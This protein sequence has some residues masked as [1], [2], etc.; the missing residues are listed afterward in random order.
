[1]ISKSDIEALVDLTGRHNKQAL[2]A[3]LVENV[4]KI[5]ASSTISVYEVFSAP[6]DRDPTDN[7]S[8]M[9]VRNTSNSVWLGEPLALHEGFTECIATKQVVRL[10][11]ENPVSTRIVF[12][13]SG[14]RDFIGLLVI[15]CDGADAESLYMIEA[16]S[17]VWKSQQFLLDRNEKDGL[18]GLLNRQALE[19][20]MPRLFGENPGN[21][22]S[23]PE[24]P[25]SKCLAML[26]LD[27]FKKVN[28][29][30]GHLFGDEVLVHFAG[31]MNKSFR[32]YDELFRYGGEEFVVILQNAEL[33][34][35]L[36]ILER[37]RNVVEMYDYPRVGRKTVSI[38][39][40]Q[41]DPGEMPSTLLDRA[42][43]ALYYAKQH[44]RNRVCAYEHLVTSGQLQERDV[45]SGD[46]ELF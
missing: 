42:D 6:G 36:S 21:L 23:E 9:V 39:V 13:V 27:K 26:D 20:R 44:G 11:R 29:K 31:L 2:T 1:M 24:P 46:I 4:H 22:Q 3:C 40:I 33:K 19:S 25:T 8:G 12:P 14:A 28:D 17:Q 37:F 16:L 43:K 18:T 32:P 45:P 5:A 10:M 41:I 35:A 34:L 30:Y 15:D 38:G 7:P